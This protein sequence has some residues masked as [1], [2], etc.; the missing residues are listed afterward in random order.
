MFLFVQA[1]KDNV[2][3]KNSGSELDFHRR[4]VA[5]DPF[6]PTFWPLSKKSD[7]KI[8]NMAPL[9]F[10]VT[11]SKTASHDF[12][13]WFPLVSQS[14]Q[15]PGFQYLKLSYSGHVVAHSGHSEAY[16]TCLE[17]HSGCLGAH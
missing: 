17:V 6:L 15:F 9:N 16:L 11:L 4:S 14:W 1:I 12:S 8:S 5:L 13:F 7:E 3:G 10:V 2:L